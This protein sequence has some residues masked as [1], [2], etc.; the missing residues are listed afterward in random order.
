MTAFTRIA[1]LTHLQFR[2]MWRDSRYFWFA[3]IFPYFMLGIFLFVGAVVPQSPGGPDFTQLVIPIALFLAITS[4]ALTITAGPLASLRS[5]GTLRLLGT[6]PVGAGR[7]LGT[8]ML[9]RLALALT[10]S[11]VLLGIAVGLGS[12]K[13]AN[14]PFLF[15]VTLLGVLLF[16]SIGYLLGGRLSSPDMATN[17]STL[18]QLGALFL[19]GLAFPYAVLPDSAADVLSLIPT[20]MFAD[21]MVRQMQGGSPVTPVWLSATVVLATSAVLATLAV[22]TF[23]WDDREAA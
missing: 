12:V 10:Q 1:E 11:V 8:H 4:T 23:R 15:A 2:E 20:S 16:G 14:L 7:F 9:V 22:R 21:L 18:V 6:T 17:I 19:S 3:L 5:K 13:L